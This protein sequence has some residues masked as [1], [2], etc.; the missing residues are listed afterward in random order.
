MYDMKHCCTRFYHRAWPKKTASTT[1]TTSEYQLGTAANKKQQSLLQALEQAAQMSGSSIAKKRSPGPSVT[2]V[3]K[4]KSQAESVAEASDRKKTSFNPA[5]QQFWQAKA[6]QQ[7]VAAERIPRTPKKSKQKHIITEPITA[8]NIHHAKDKGCILSFM[9]DRE[10]A[11]TPEPD[12][13][14]VP[15]V[16][17]PDANQPN[18]VQVDGDMQFL[19]DPGYNLMYHTKED[20]SVVYEM[21][22][23]IPGQT[24]YN[25]AENRVVETAQVLK[26]GDAAR[27]KMSMVQELEFDTLVRQGSPMKMAAKRVI[28]TAAPGFVQPETVD[29]AEATA[30]AQ[31]SDTPQDAAL[32]VTGAASTITNVTVTATAS[33]VLLPPA[34]P[35]ELEER[36]SR[37]PHRRKQQSPCQAE[38]SP[39]KQQSPCPTEKSPGEGKQQSPRPAEKSPDKQ[40]SPRRAAKSPGEGKQESPCPAAKSPGKGVVTYSD[41]ST[42]T[43]SDKSARRKLSFEDPPASPSGK[44]KD[45]DMEEVDI[46]WGDIADF[47]LLSC[48]QATEKAVASLNST[49][50]MSEVDQNRIPQMPKEND[51]VNEACAEAKEKLRVEN[52]SNEE[53]RLL[54]MNAIPE[55]EWKYPAE[56]G[57]T[58]KPETE[59][60][61]DGLGD[62]KAKRNDRDERDESSSDED[63]NT[64]LLNFKQPP[65]AVADLCVGDYVLVKEND[66]TGKAFRG[67]VEQITPLKIRYYRQKNA[68]HVSAG[69]TANDIMHDADISDILCVIEA[70]VLLD[71]NRKQGAMRFPALDPK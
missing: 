60:D 50:L 49:Q 57:G 64:P 11:A 53:C 15:V 56:K 5:M 58:P 35:S 67:L 37:S 45:P 31:K 52:I 70:M 16:N 12:T 28:V 66:E 65:K 47:Q 22:R 26:E 20:G 46:D 18:L 63:D 41:S 23:L 48:T 4:S 38:K 44:S 25:V 59:I 17:E 33:D 7:E 19:V 62:P 1:L 29:I 32:T 39:G 43:S 27:S 69:W 14:T 61:A 40:E 3:T 55:D 34:Q 8:H 24:N 13:V 71:E 6:A 10:K 30:P 2:T 9:A 36:S 42:G 68:S 21:V 51:P 54:A